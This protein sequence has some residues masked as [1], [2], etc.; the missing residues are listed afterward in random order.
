MTDKNNLQDNLDLFLVTS[1]IPGL[2]RFQSD[3][4]NPVQNFHLQNFPS[5]N[6]VHDD[7]D[8]THHTKQQELQFSI[9]EALKI[10]TVR[11]LTYDAR[12]SRIFYLTSNI[13]YRERAQLNRLQ[14]LHNNL[15]AIF[16]QADLTDGQ[17][18]NVSFNR[19]ITDLAYD[20]VSKNM[21]MNVKHSI[22]VI[23]VDNPW[24]VSQLIP[25]RGRIIS[26]AVHPTKGYLFFAEENYKNIDSS[27]I[28]RGHLDGSNLVKIRNKMAA[29]LAIDYYSDR[30]YWSVPYQGIIQHSNL[31]GTDVKSIKVE[32]VYL[33]L[34][35]DGSRSIAI[36][37]DYI[38]YLTANSRS[39]RRIRKSDETE[40]EGFQLQNLEKIPIVE[41]VIY[42]NETQIVPEDHPC[43]DST[44]GCEKFCFAIPKDEKLGKVCGCSDGEKLSDDG[45]SCERRDNEEQLRLI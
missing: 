15:E 9:H 30:L 12:N 27:G 34:V 22:S 16:D 36:D 26:I 10:T 40:D 20:W 7:S 17:G 13:L 14:L 39:V 42:N 1:V 3:K 38:Y 37:N 35:N 21:Y 18:T 41:V 31:D 2:C 25:K 45:V 8:L 44:G 29:N 6:L 43:K 19:E 24:K 23:N 33:G 5:Y 28:Y 11:G 4:T 32:R